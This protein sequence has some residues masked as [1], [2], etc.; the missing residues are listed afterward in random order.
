MVELF[1]P[2]SDKLFLVALWCCTFCAKI[3]KNP[4]FEKHFP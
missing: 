2:Y 1:E 3:N 4:K